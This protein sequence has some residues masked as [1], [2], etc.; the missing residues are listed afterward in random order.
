MRLRWRNLR[1]LYVC[2]HGS[3]DDLPKLVYLRFSPC[4]V[5]NFF[6]PLAILIETSDK[7]ILVVLHLFG[8]PQSHKE[9]FILDL[10]ETTYHN[11]TLLVLSPDNNEQHSKVVLVWSRIKIEI[12]IADA[13]LHWGC[14]FFNSAR[15]TWVVI[16]QHLTC[17]IWSRIDGELVS[18]GD[19]SLNAT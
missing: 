14:E 17:T 11:N 19:I 1:L 4:Q 7:S 16:K 10:V 6:F 13:A 15:S 5:V 18:H 9:P 8:E 12:G 2:N 3:N